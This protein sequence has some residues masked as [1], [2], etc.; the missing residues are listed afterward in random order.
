MS[1]LCLVVH[2]LCLYASKLLSVFFWDKDEVWLF[3]VKTGWQPWCGTD[4]VCGTY[5]FFLHYCW[6][7]AKSITFILKFLYLPMSN[8]SQLSRQLLQPP[9]GSNTD[10]SETQT[11]YQSVATLNGLNQY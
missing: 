1:I 8:L 3:S 2:V 9:V 7:A 5:E 6:R 11:R 4:F 10:V